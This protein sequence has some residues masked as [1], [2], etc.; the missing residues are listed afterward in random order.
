M[1]GLIDGDVV[2]HMACKNR[3]LTKEGVKIINTGSREFTRE[4]DSKYLRECWNN[5]TQLMRNLTEDLFLTDFLCAMKSPLNYRDML[6]PEYKKTS[7][8]T[9]DSQKKGRFVSILRELAVREDYAVFAHGREADDLLRI[10]ATQCSEM[11]E[12]FIVISIDK[13]LYCIPGLHYDI[14]KKEIREISELQA[15]RFFYE[16]LLKGDPTDNIP[17]IPGIGPVGATNALAQ[18]KDELE[19]Q[20]VV[21]EM[22]QEFFGPFWYNELL[23]NGKLLYLQKHEDD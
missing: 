12:E 4:E 21:V 22:Y 10:W 6:Y 19:M 17:G 2:A 15:S 11:D 1:I 20:Q 14:K 8:R 23:T 9:G 3:F 5:F 13:D 7:S 18:C 16:Q